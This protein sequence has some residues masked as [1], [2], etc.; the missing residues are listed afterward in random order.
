[1]SSW[2]PRSLSATI[3][4]ADRDGLRRPEADGMA[5]IGFD[6]WLQVQT[7]VLQQWSG[8]LGTTG[9]NGELGGTGTA[10]SFPF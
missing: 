9:T 3:E 7:R 4:E 6:R 2:R 8:E 10:G 5:Q 1:M